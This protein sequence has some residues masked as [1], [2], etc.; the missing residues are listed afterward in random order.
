MAEYFDSFGDIPTKRLEELRASA[1]Q[2][3]KDAIRDQRQ[4]CLFVE[5]A[6]SPMPGGSG[7]HE[8]TA[9]NWGFVNAPMLT[10]FAAKAVRLMMSYEPGLPLAAALSDVERSVMSNLGQAS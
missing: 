7:K 6:R 1:C 4:F 2:A 8:I 3:M 9:E 5:M 10:V